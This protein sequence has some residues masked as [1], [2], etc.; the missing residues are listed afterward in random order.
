MAQ[1]RINA[2]NVPYQLLHVL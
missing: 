2:A 1:I